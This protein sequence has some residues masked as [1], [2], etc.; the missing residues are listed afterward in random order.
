MHQMKEG[1]SPPFITIA[2]LFEDSAYLLTV[3]GVPYIVLT[4]SST[5]NLIVII[6]SDKLN[7]QTSTTMDS[8]TQTDEADSHIVRIETRH[9]YIGT[10][11]KKPP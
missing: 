9:Y 1:K 7:A 3:N 4:F 5:V 10:A 6:F 11:S 2:N 8:Q